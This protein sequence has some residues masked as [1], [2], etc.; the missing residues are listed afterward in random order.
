MKYFLYTVW[1]CLLSIPSLSAQTQAKLSVT[2]SLYEPGDVPAEQATV[3]LLSLPDSAFVTGASTGKT[4]SF[5]L[6]NIPGGIYLLHASYLGFRSLYKTVELTGKQPVV[7]A[8]KLYFETDDVLLKEA[9]VVGKANEVVVKN[10][11]IE[12]N[13]ASYKTEE[14]AVV[15][16]LLKKLPGVEVD[17][18]GK[19]TIGGKEI[20]KILVDGKEFFSDDPKVASKNLP[21]NMIEKLQVLDQK[22]DMSRMTGFDD[23]EEQTVINLTVKPGM[24]RGTVMN[25][26]AGMGHDAK[27]NPGDQRYD[28]A[29][30]VNQMNNDDRYSL[31]FNSNNTN[32]M[33]ASDMGGNRFGG[34]RGMRRGGNSGINTSQ[35]YAL[36]MNKEF[37]S[38]LLLNGDV[39]YNASDRDATRQTN[40]STT[41]KD[42]DSL[43]TL[44]E[45]T[46]R[47]IND[48]SDNIGLNFRLE[49]KPDENNKLIFRPN[50]SHNTSS[51]RETQGFSSLAGSSASDAVSSGSSESYNEGAGHAFGGSLEYA[52]QFNTTG[53][54]FSVSLTGNYN[55]SFSQEIYNWDRHYYQRSQDSTVVQRSE[56]D[57]TTRSFRIYTSYVEPLGKEYFL[58][59]AYRYSQSNTQN[60][61]STYDID[62]DAGNLAELNALQSRSTVRE[63]RDQR[64]SINIKSMHEKYNYTVGLNI[65]PAVSTNK[66]HQPTQPFTPGHVPDNFADRLPNFLGD[67]IVSTIDRD[68]TNFSPAINFNY[69]FG[70]RTN[71]R[72]DYSG[73]T[74]QPSASQLRDYTDYSNPQN[75]VTG[76]PGLKS[77]YQHS[78]NARFDKFVPE[79]QLFYNFRARG[80]MSFNDVGSLVTI[81]PLKGTRATTYDNINGN[82]NANIMAMANL[83]L[84]NKKFSVNTFLSASYDNRRS[85]TNA[86]LNTMNT[87]GI[88]DRMGINYR[89][90]LFDLGAG[91]SL[92]YS[93]T[94]NE[95]T[96]DNNM[97]TYDLGFTANTTWYLPLN[98]TINSDIAWNGRRGYGEGFNKNET[99]W[100]AS[101]TKQLFSR[102]AGTGSLRLKIYDILQDRKSINRSVGD[103]Y[104]E[105]SMSTILPSFFM[106][107]FIY[108][109]NFFPGGSSQKDFEPRHGDPRG[110]GGGRSRSA[111]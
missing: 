39:S 8:G 85:Y 84:R 60:L 90:E 43:R 7:D 58:Q 3:R 109:L 18:D 91:G 96:P 22:S 99:M 25:A 24:K 23:G 107:S 12:Y 86:V 100:N 62:D 15:E 106:C 29:G 32:N 88:R 110:G 46:D 92:N 54:V 21:V 72:I 71:L 50:Y 26:A 48:R 37:G 31:I 55:E 74:T 33:G 87:F 10:D 67:S 2:G 47:V 61:N 11:T 34:M 77:G 42:R 59:L 16:D 63:S 4:G 5:S 36:N 44:I 81:D 70:Q 30:M 13:A 102:K 78:L 38:T 51:S 80:T 20:K 9:L 111:F 49:W 17:A 94:R 66:T 57:N 35:T 64:F 6:K 45:N 28:V 68:V 108:R 97:Q 56:N 103:N 95:L 79:S 69:I 89:S 19:I 83:P 93:D 101:I 73:T 76:N 82:W 14:N 53:R 52:H 75:T 105:D 41:Y 98:F 40:R 1:I 65:D 104:I 27:I